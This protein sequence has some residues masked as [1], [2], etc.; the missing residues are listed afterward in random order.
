LNSNSGH[1]GSFSFII[2]SCGESR[3]F[4][5]WC[6]GSRCDMTDSDENLG[7]SK[8]HGAEEQRWSSIGRVLGGR[9]IGRSGDAM[10]GLH[11]AHRDKEHGFLD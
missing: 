1:F 11:R 5:T 3:L 10:Y 9:T 7:R 4:V 2:V 8:R 6:A